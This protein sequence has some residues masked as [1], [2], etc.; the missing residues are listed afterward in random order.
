MGSNL[1]LPLVKK[2][3]NRIIVAESNDAYDYPSEKPIGSQP[4]YR[5]GAFGRKP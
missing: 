5:H 4:I 2:S 3:P 1:Y